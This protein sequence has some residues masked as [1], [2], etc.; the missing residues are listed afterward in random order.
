MLSHLQKCFKFVE[1][2]KELVTICAAV[3]QSV[4]LSTT[5]YSAIHTARSNLNSTFLKRYIKSHLIRTSYNLDFTPINIARVQTN[6]RI[7]YL[8]INGITIT[9][10]VSKI[11]LKCKTI[12]YRIFAA[13]SIRLTSPPSAP[14]TVLSTVNVT[15]IGGSSTLNGASL[16]TYW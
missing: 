16:C 8:K 10:S 3:H 4:G 12:N 14:P 5:S 11:D 7:N 9:A 15:V 2:I 13:R 6:R 1:F